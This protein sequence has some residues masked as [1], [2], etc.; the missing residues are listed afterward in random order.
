MRSNCRLCAIVI[1]VAVIL[2]GG[3]TGTASCV[4]VSADTASAATALV[5][6][7]AG[8]GTVP[9]PFPGPDCRLKSG[10]LLASV[11]EL[12]QNVPA[13]PGVLGNS[14]ATALPL[15]PPRGSAKLTAMASHSAG[16]PFRLAVLR[17]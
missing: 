3:R 13:P 8:A 11:S 6:A 16:T 4:T 1:L 17:L 14:L 12:A 9:S 2:A 10:S 7:L 15:L 5:P